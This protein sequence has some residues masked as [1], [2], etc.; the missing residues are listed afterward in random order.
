MVFQANTWEGGGDDEQLAILPANALY[1]PTSSPQCLGHLT[2]CSAYLILNWVTQQRLCVT[3]VFCHMGSIS[4]GTCMLSIAT[5]ET[6]TPAP[7]T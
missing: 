2:A 7:V 1:G 6:S 4:V 5:F 3:M